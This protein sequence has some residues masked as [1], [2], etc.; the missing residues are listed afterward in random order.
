MYIPQKCSIKRDLGEN[1]K[2]LSFFLKFQ[3]LKY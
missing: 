3:R 1:P 2:S